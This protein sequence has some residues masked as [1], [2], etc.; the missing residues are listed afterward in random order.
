MK[1]IYEL[2]VDFDPND[3]WTD[4]VR[5]IGYFES[6][7]LAKTAAAYIVEEYKRHWPRVT[8]DALS[9]KHKLFSIISLPVWHTLEEM[10]DDMSEILLSILETKDFS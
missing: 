7:E 2:Y 3:V 8:E 4:S 10:D 1:E 5:H 6:E 9:K